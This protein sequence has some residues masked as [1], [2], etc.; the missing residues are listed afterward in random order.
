MV[1]DNHVPDGGA[2]AAGLTVLLL[3]PVPAGA[4]RGLHHV[5]GLVDGCAGGLET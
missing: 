2:V 5:L 4:D 3:P 1:G